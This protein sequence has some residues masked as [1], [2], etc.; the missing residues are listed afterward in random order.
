MQPSIF[1]PGIAV[2][3]LLGIALDRLGMTAWAKANNAFYWL[4]S[5]SLMVAGYFVLA[6]FG[7]G[8]EAFY[9]ELFGL[10]MGFRVSGALATRSKTRTE[11]AELAAQINNALAA[12]GAVNISL[13][14]S[15]ISPRVLENQITALVKTGY[16]VST[17]RQCNDNKVSLKITTG[18]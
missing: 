4:I 2:F 10:V 12:D 11:K 13:D 5:I 18:G 6:N 3:M 14:V 17:L 16:K 8:F 9:V 7:R 15:S 1:L